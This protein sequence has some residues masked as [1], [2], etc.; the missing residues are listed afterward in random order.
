MVTKSCDKTDI[1]PLRS[2]MWV[3]INTAICKRDW[4][5]TMLK[6]CLYKKMEY[7]SVLHNINTL[8]VTD[9]VVK[10]FITCKEHRGEIAF[11]LGTSWVFAF[12]LSEKLGI[13]WVYSLFICLNLSFPR[14]QRVSVETGQ[15]PLWW[16]RSCEEIM[17]FV[18]DGKTLILSR[19][20]KSQNIRNDP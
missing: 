17:I 18:F 16:H 8:C 12:H 6:V 20:D 19:Q 4:R 5:S 9:R 7:P 11:K 13:I 10:N 2:D 15:I 1:Y 14:L 3:F